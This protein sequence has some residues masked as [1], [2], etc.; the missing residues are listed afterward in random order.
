MWGMAKD[1]LP[2]RAYERAVIAGLVDS[3][4]DLPA[5]GGEPGSIYIAA[6][7]ARSYLWDG[8]AWPPRAETRKPASMT[9]EPPRLH[10]WL[11]NARSL[12]D[13]AS[14]E[15]SGY[16]EGDLEAC[17]GCLV[18]A[19]LVASWGRGLLEENSRPPHT[20]E[21]A[22]DTLVGT[23]WTP[24]VPELK[25]MLKNLTFQVFKYSGKAS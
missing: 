12:C 6:D 18:L 14:R 9:N 24:L 17:Q 4:D 3:Y 1:E 22:V 10:I 23:G 21:E 13:R 5:D 19:D 16:Y 15:A 20:P 11:P 2:K 7:T 8:K 25:L